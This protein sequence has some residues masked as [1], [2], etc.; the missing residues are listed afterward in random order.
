MKLRLDPLT[1]DK[2]EYDYYRKPKNKTDW[3]TDLEDVMT[4]SEFI[5]MSGQ[6]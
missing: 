5:Q 6:S 2:W 1:H 3:R 4:A